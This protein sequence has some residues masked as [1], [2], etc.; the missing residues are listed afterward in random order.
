MKKTTLWIVALL[1]IATLAGCNS[2]KTPV[3]NPE[4]NAEIANPASVYCK[5]KGGTLNLE[6]WLCMF[7][8]GSYCEEW[9]YQRWE[10]QPGEN[11]DITAEPAEP[12]YEINYGASEIYSEEDLKSAVNAIMNVFNNEWDIKCDM[13]KL[14]YLWDELSMANLNYCKIFYSDIKECA[15]FSSNFHIPNTDQQLAWSFEPDTDI[16]WWTWYLWRATGEDW[17]VLTNG[18]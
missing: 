9:A 15:V 3:E 1:A 16:E 7:E 2:N 4:Q 6:E 17:I 13:K 12:T 11:S 10:C 8:D 18:L 14:N 5:E